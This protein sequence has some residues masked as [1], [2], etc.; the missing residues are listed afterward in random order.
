M[1]ANVCG[2]LLFLFVD[3]SVGLLLGSGSLDSL[4]TKAIILHQQLDRDQRL[5]RNS[6]VGTLAPSKGRLT[7]PMAD[8]DVVLGERGAPHT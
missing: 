3:N 4:T 1:R 7:C 5:T 2:L 6:D 8:W